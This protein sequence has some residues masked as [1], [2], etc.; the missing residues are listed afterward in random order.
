[1][2]CA[3]CYGA[4]PPCIVSSRRTNLW[5]R[6]VCVL[7]FELPTLEATRICQLVGGARALRIGALHYEVVQSQCIHGVVRGAASGRKDIG[8]YAHCSPNRI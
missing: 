6:T 5:G 8:C 4:L 7:A 1:M 2:Y 3:G